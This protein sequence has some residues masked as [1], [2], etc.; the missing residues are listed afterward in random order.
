MAERRSSWPWRKK[1]APKVDKASLFSP[2]QLASPATSFKAEETPQI[3]L[4]WRQEAAAASFVEDD[5]RVLEAISLREQAEDSLKALK[6]ELSTAMK[7]TIAKE[8][9]VKQHEKVAEEAVSGWEKAEKEALSFKQEL[10]A[11]TQQKA[12]LEDRVA[13]LDGALK[14]CMRQVRHVI[15]E[16]EGK[17]EEAISCKTREWEKIKAEVDAKQAELERRL[18]ESDAQNSAM[19]KSL[20]ERA[21]KILEANEVKARAETEV[22]V[23]QVKLGSSEKEISALK[24]ELH[25][26]NKELEIRNEEVDYSKKSADAAHKQHLDNVKKMAKLEADCQRLRSLVRK[27]LPGPAAIA[28]MR[29]EAEVL[30]VRESVTGDTK[31]RPNRSLTSSTISFTNSYQNGAASNNRDVE[32][33]RDRM[34]SM[35]EENNLLKEALSKRNGDLQASRLLC[36]KTA[37]KLSIAEDQLESL[38][39]TPREVRMN[40]FDTTEPSI[41]S[42]SAEEEGNGNDAEEASCAESWASALI[43]EL[44]HFKKDNPTSKE[45]SEEPTE[46]CNNIDPSPSLEEARADPVS[47]ASQVVLDQEGSIE[48]PLSEAA[49]L[50]LELGKKVV[51]DQEGSIESPLPGAAKLTLELG[52]NLAN[53][54]AFLQAFNAHLQALNLLCKDLDCKL[55]AIEEQLRALKPENEECTSQV[56]EC[57]RGLVDAAHQNMS[58]LERA[59]QGLGNGVQSSDTLGFG[60]ITPASVG[61]N[62]NPTGLVTLN[63]E[64]LSSSARPIPVSGLRFVLGKLI[65]LLGMLP[66]P[67]KPAEQ[68]EETTVDADGQTKPKDET[69]TEK[70]PFQLDQQNQALVSSKDNFLHGKSSVLDFLLRVGVALCEACHSDSSELE[71]LLLKLNEGGLGVV[72]VNAAGYLSEISSMRD[73]LEQV[74]EAKAELEKQVAATCQELGDTKVELGENKQLAVHLQVQVADLHNVK[75]KLSDEEAIKAELQAKLE[76]AE[77][78]V[79]KLQACVASLTLE[80]VDQR[81]LYDGVVTKCDELE[82]KLQGFTVEDE[83]KAFKSPIDEETRLRKERELVAAKEKL[84]ECQ[85]T[86][87]VL[88]KQLTA[89]SSPPGGHSPAGSFDTASMDSASLD[90][91]M[92]LDLHASSS[93]EYH[94]DASACCNANTQSAHQ[95]HHNSHHHR[96]PPPPPPPPPHQAWAPQNG[97]RYDEDLPHTPHGWS[98]SNVS[99]KGACHVSGPQDTDHHH[100]HHHHPA[101]QQP[102]LRTSGPVCVPPHYRYGRRHRHHHYDAASLQQRGPT[103]NGTY[104]YLPLE[105]EDGHQQLALVVYS[106]PHTAMSSPARSPA[107]YVQQLG[108]RR[109]AVRTSLTESMNAAADSSTTNFSPAVPPKPAGSSSFGRLFSRSKNHR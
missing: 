11:A 4:N 25:V 69:A 57:L 108:G 99:V 87:L 102:Q 19:S 52:N 31:R 59:I 107:R 93:F 47:T 104:S 17:I 63:T 71:D 70:T 76:T 92:Q 95:Y 72:D 9:L 81:K 96:R 13:H 7:E 26:L 28:Q 86:I 49:K 24:Y 83:C 62:L 5:G 21:K 22:K 109:T 51:L 1:S 38:Q 41:A 6:E 30:P 20:Q 105:E 74:M 10:D 29:K 15:E 37:N 42:V 90:Q 98:P 73:Q 18:M 27:K 45:T 61:D 60:A 23:L 34:F 43:S 82:H 89:L 68:T 16:Q 84:T 48:S 80:L 58:E 79:S 66:P 3:G 91:R 35:E 75:K 2:S 101:Y 106:P 8:A 55:S 44:A 94:Q 78:E 85:R 33:L 97:R 36:A 77:V 12:I 53:Q 100:H 67:C 56:G 64:E 32:M 88:G 39:G 46:S 103:S 50:T 14:E 54:E 65:T 40:G